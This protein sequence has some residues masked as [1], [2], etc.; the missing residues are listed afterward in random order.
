M[1]LREILFQAAERFPDRE[2]IV[3]G[4]RRVSYREWLD[5]VE[6]LAE[7]LR[8][9]GVSRGD[10]VAVGLRNSLEHVT[11]FYALQALGAAAVP[12]NIRLKPERIAHVIN[13]SGSKLA[14]IDGSVDETTLGRGELFAKDFPWIVASDYP[15]ASR[16]GADWTPLED[17]LA[18]SPGPV[19]LPAV[20]EDDLSVIIYTSGTTGLPKGVPLTHREAYD[21]LVTYIMSVGP[22]F[23]SGTRTL[24][25]AP[26]YHTVGMHWIF[27]QTVLTNGTYYAEPKV[28][29]GTAELIQREGLTYLF[30]SPT[31]FKMLLEKDFDRPAESVTHIAYGSAPVGQELLDMLQRNFPRAMITEVYGTTELSIPFVTPSMTGREPGTLRRTADHRLRVVE[32]G[33]SVENEVDAGELGELVVHMGNPG[34]FRSYWGPEGDAKLAKNV[35]DGW[36]R[37]GDGFRRDD[38]GNYY[39]DGRLDD[40]FVSGGENIQPAEVENALNGCER[41]LDSAV[42]GTPDSTWGFVISALVV[43]DSPSLTV[44]ELED[45]FR[46]CDLENFKR[47]RR[48]HFVDEIPRNPSGKIVRAELGRKLEEILG[49]TAAKDR[50]DADAD[51][52]AGADAG[53]AAR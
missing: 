27:L 47:P 9:R 20:D 28:G 44:G 46:S 10:R 25:A 26:L 38:D 4:D 42:F 29:P 39:F 31:L 17:L 33:G 36:F 3:D 43:P 40:M 52:D 30:G 37:T 32:I 19:S 53:A 50:A 21:R 41:V 49:S 14:V 34:V 24:G 15:A 51:A 16:T 11:V 8:R 1:H 13:D 5:L 6:S 2:A 48:I 35:E 12:F 23:D 7:S 22:T 45:Y 18:A